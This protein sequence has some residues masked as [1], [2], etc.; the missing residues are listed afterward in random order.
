MFMGMPNEEGLKARG[1]AN[2]KEGI[3]TL[4]LMLIGKS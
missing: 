3:G 1:L 2:G 4:M